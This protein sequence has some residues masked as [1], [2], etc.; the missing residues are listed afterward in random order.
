MLC[1]WK[2]KYRPSLELYYYG[3]KWPV[4]FID[5]SKILSF[6]ASGILRQ[7]HELSKQLEYLRIDVTLFSKTHLKPHEKFF[8]Q[9]YHVYRIDRYSGRKGGTAIAV[10]KVIPHNHVDLP[11]TPYFSKSDRGLHT[12]WK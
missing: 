6:N 10:R 8:F 7:C 1:Q 12:C 11:S 4:E 9:N 2:L 3:T 5:L